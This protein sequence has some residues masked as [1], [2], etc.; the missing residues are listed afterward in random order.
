MWNET[1]IGTRQQTKA[2]L[3]TRNHAQ[4]KVTAMTACS[5]CCKQLAGKTPLSN[6]HVQFENKSHTKDP[7]GKDVKDGLG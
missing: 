2:D 1:Q 7:H 6:E 4:G 5:F 3:V